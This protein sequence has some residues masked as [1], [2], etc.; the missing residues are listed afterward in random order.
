M[1]KFV[2]GTIPITN[3]R[4]VNSTCS[5]DEKNY[6]VSYN[7]SSAGYGSDT[8]AVVFGD[9]LF[10]VLNGDHRKEMSNCNTTQK[11]FDYFFSKIS[12]ANRISEHHNVVGNMKDV[13]GLRKLALK[14]LGADNVARLEKVAKV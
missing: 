2:H 11:G 13:F 5:F 8:T 4:T 6:H 14:Y 10:F 9:T 12:E 1:N 7:P 3:E